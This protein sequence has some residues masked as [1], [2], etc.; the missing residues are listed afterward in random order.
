MLVFLLIS[1][2][3]IV[4]VLGPRAKVVLHWRAQ[5]SRFTHFDSSA[6]SGAAN[7]KALRA[8]VANQEAA[9]VGITPGADKHI[10]FSSESRPKR[11]EFV[12]LYIHGYSATR[13]EIV[14]VPQLVARAFNA[15]LYSTRLTGHGL[16][17]EALANST[18]NDWLHDIVEAWHVA[19][20]LGDKVIVMSTSTG[21]SL[22]TWMA[23][24]SEVKKHLAALIMVSPNFQP[25]HWASPLFLLPWAAYWMPKLAGQ[26]YGRKP[27]S[28]RAASFWTYRYPM[29]G[30][31]TMTSLVAAVRHSNLE[32]I[33]APSL[34]IY[35]N[36]DRV[37][38]PKHT[39]AAFNRWGSAVKQRIA[40]AGIDGDNNHVITGDIVRP[41]TTDDISQDIIHFIKHYAQS[42]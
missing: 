3:A 20:L 32:G 14:P 27:D 17:G 11:T 25:L 33:L 31:T 34:F 15:N 4:F 13:Q 18:A 2:L 24:Q 36:A 10:E 9:V 8:E 29:R 22:V 39:D 42:G 6:Q 40:V 21:G 7:L 19:R 38:S 37:V 12:V 35:S 5:N 23:Q 41:Q 30:L 26:Y 28:E 1:V 16:D